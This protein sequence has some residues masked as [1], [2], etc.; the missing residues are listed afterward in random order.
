MWIIIIVIAVFVIWYY[1]FSGKAKENMTNE[2][3]IIDD[4]KTLSSD[5]GKTVLKL[6][7]NKLVLLYNGKEVF[8]F[9]EDSNVNYK[10]LTMGDNG[11]LWLNY[12]DNK[13][14]PSMLFI[15]KTGT[16]DHVVIVQNGKMM[17]TS[18]ESVIF[19]VP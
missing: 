14:D 3:I 13:Y 6:D 15:G 7:G 5:G 19:M 10:S 17:V 1:F 2:N 16:R 18:G 12:I 8:N 4:K 9:S 11:E